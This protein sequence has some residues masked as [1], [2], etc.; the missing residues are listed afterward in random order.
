MRSRSPAA[1]VSLRRSHLPLHGLGIAHIA[2][3]AL[4]LGATGWPALSV[5]GNQ[6]PVGTSG[7]VSTAVSTSYIFQTADF[8]FTDPNDSPPDSLSAVKITTLPASGSLTLN[9]FAVTAGELVSAADIAGGSLVFTPMPGET[10]LPYSSF[11]FQVQ[12]NGT[13]NTNHVTLL[14]N[15]NAIASD[16][17]GSRSATAPLATPSRPQLTVTAEVT[18]GVNSW[19]TYQPSVP[20]VTSTLFN[21]TVTYPTLYLD[22]IDGPRSTRWVFKNAG[23]EV[24]AAGLATTT[25]TFTYVFGVAGLGGDPSENQTTTSSV[26]LTVL[27]NGD[28][29]GTNFYSLLDGQSTDIATNPGAL[30]M[31]GTQISTASPAVISQGYTFFSLPSGASQI[32]LQETGADAHGIVFGVVETSLAATLDAN[33]KTL[34]INIRAAAPAAVPSLGIGGLLALALG[35]AGIARRRGRSLVH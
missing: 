16:L 7:T 8:G 21:A 23:S 24:S 13:G 29:F 35:V 28:A 2:V 9:G 22:E 27:A 26:P 5:A 34:A 18:G 25:S 32:S 15:Q 12:D 14:T 10:G 4:V 17:N 1:P 30:G 20:I 31:S 6:A 19:R 11:T 3:S 33:P